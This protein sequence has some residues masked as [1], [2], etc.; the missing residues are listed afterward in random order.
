[1]IWI[2][3]FKCQINM[4]FIY[5]QLHHQQL[6]QQGEAQLLLQLLPVVMNKLGGKLSFSHWKTLRK[7]PPA[8]KIQFL[9]TLWQKKKKSGLVFDYANIFGWEKEIERQI[10]KSHT[11]MQSKFIFLLS[12]GMS[13]CPVQDCPFAKT[14]I[15]NQVEKV[16]VK[17]FENQKDRSAK[18]DIFSP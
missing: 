11:S 10:L 5:V 4:F 8:T 1:M 12:G 15:K 3:N 16:V 18:R 6:V 9:R 2:Y 13:N 7:I 14:K 17:F